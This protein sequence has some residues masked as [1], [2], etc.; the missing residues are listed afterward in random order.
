MFINNFLI[1]FGLFLLGC[2][3]HKNLVLQSSI[4]LEN[5]YTLVS[6]SN[7]NKI[8]EQNLQQPG[9]EIYDDFCIQCHGANG[10]G[11]GKNF[12]PLDGSDWL[13]K[14]RTQSIHA[15]KFGQVGAI[16][17]NKK[18]FNNIMPP[19]GL[20]NEEVADVMNYIMNSW[21][22]KQSKKVTIEEVA[23]IKK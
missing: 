7:S 22:N 9:K 8:I 6:K 4:I 19:M 15:V 1:S 21:G 3:P 16:I 17:V 10:K 2:F 14:K 18:T 11:D 12:P 23:N 13:T 5:N 20:S